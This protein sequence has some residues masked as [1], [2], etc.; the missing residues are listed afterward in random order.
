MNCAQL[1]ALRWP[2]NFAQDDISP[3]KQHTKE[4]PKAA[5]QQSTNNLWFVSVSI[6]GNARG[7]IDHW[8]LAHLDEAGCWPIKVEDQEQDR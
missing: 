7:G 4:P 6:C 8:L 5:L 3:I 1:Y 2:S